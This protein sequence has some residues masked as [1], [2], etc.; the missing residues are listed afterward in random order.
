MKRIV[1]IGDEALG[2]AFRLAGAEAH[3]PAAAELAAVFERACA[4]AA[5][6][7]L[8][9]RA[10]AALPSTQLARQRAQ[11]EPLLVVLPDPQATGDEDE[12]AR[13]MHAV[14]GIET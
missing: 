6:L 11:L 3:A 9:H 5:L 4:E 7:V 12:L 2:A 10:A 13:R 1:F 8:S 14:L